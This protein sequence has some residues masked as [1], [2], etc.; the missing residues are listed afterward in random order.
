MVI[1]FLYDNMCSTRLTGTSGRAASG[2]DRFLMKVDAPGGSGGAPPDV[3][4]LGETM[5]MVTPTPGG[6]LDADSSF[7]LRA[8]GA[9]SNVAMFMAELGHRA[10]WLSRVGSDPLGALLLSEVAAT[11]VDTSMVEISPGEPTGVYF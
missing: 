11:G 10:A 9:E 4:C 5:V 7:V 6:H 8:G 3:L 1:R 2:G